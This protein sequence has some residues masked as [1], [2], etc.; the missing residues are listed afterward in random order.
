MEL[1]GRRK[2]EEIE[3]KHK[4][5]VEALIAHGIMPKL[6]IIQTI[7][8]KV[9]DLYVNV[10]KKYA[11]RIGVEVEHVQ[12]EPNEVRQ[13]IEQYN[14]DVK[15]HGI[16]VQLPLDATLIVQDV[17]AYVSPEKDVDGLVPHSSYVPPTAQAVHMLLQESGRDLQTEKIALV[18][19]GT[20]VGRPTKKLFETKGIHTQVFVKGDDLHLLQKYT[21]IVSGVGVPGLIL[22][23]DIQSN[24]LIID[25]GTAEDSGSIVGDVEESLYTRTDVIVSAKKGGVGLLTVRGLFENV[26]TAAEAVQ[27]F[28]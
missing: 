14:N 28:Q 26:L 10:K 21:V 4:A 16:I 22:N 13:A 8:S 19:Y 9:I 20:L 12:V 3:I 15:V 24:T 23:Q 18:G 7:E 6:V 5:R 25:A 11:Q 2:A 1:S 17:L 27:N